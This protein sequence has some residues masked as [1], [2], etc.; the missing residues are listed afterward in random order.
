MR[1]I[2]L[3]FVAGAFGLVGAQPALAGFERGD[4]SLQFGASGVHTQGSERGTISGDLSY[5]YFLTDGIELG[6]LQGVN[7]T[8]IEDD[9][10]LWSAS[11]IGFANDNFGTPDSTFVP[12]IGA[13]AGAA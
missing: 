3:A 7:Y 13:F 9:D 6:V 12:F 10:D 2:A 1:S 5:G 11:T 8:I 4:S